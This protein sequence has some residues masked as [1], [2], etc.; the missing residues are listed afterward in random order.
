MSNFLASIIC[1]VV[2]AVVGAV[3]AGVA[4]YLVTLSQH[5]REKKEKTLF[6]LVDLALLIENAKSSSEHD[7]AREP[8]IKSPHFADETLNYRF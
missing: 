8:L 6:L 1:A 3:I 4:T 2:G 5:K 7:H